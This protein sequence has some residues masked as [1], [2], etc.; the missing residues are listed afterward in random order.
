MEHF[1]VLLLY[2]ALAIILIFISFCA[3]LNTV[4]TF[5]WHEVEQSI[6]ESVTIISLRV[7]DFE[8]FWDFPWVEH[9][10][11]KLYHPTWQKGT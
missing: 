7:G 9:G 5:Y 6:R 1:I 11:S 3:H 8:F 4:K 10:R 2:M